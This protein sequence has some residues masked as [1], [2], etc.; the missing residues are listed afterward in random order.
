MGGPKVSGHNSGANNEGSALNVICIVGV[1]RSGSTLLDRMIGSLPNAVSLNELRPLW[2]NGFLNNRPCACG[3]RFN[4]CEFWGEIRRRFERQCKLSPEQLVALHDRVDRTRW[5]G[6]LLL[7]RKHGRFAENLRA[8]REVLA[9]LYGAIAETTGATTIID[10][11]KVPSRALILAGIPGMK[12]E[13]LHIIRDIRGVAYSWTKLR[14]DPSLDGNIPQYSTLRSVA[15]W[16]HRNLFIEGLGLK[17]PYHR[18]VYEDLVA[19][20]RSEIERLADEM[21]SLAGQQAEFEGERAINLRMVHSLSGSTHRFE[22]GLTEI[23]SDDKWRRALP[24][25]TQS[26]IKVLS[27]PL[28]ARYGLPHIRRAALTPNGTTVDPADCHGAR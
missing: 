25:K 10:S 17:L 1:G 3:S 16:Y 11:S 13:L 7:D 18:V 6:A 22:T 4:D 28:M 15:F 14:H 19:N 12:V 27:W 8:Y 21:P 24:L 2:R 9:A 20:P 5:I 26:L 23:R